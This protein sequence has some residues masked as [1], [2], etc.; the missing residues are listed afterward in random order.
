MKKIIFV[1]PQFKNGGGNRVFIELANSIHRNFFYNLE[2]AFPNN[3][4]ETNHY[5]IEKNIEIKKIGKLATNIFTKLYNTFFL[6]RY[7]IMSIKNN[8]NTIIVISDPILCV[9][10]F[11][12][13]SR[14]H[15]NIIR[16]IQADDYKIYDDL[17][18]LKNSMFL[19]F[20]KFLTKLNFKLKLS[21]IF[22]STFT[23]NCFIEI[24]KRT[25]VPKFIV[26]PAVDKNI[27]YFSK[28]IKQVSNKKI[29]L[30]LVARDHPLKK[31]E[32]FISVWRELPNETLNEIE[33][34][35]LISTDKLDKFDLKEF[36]L[37]RPSSDFEIASIM[38]KSDIFISTSMWEGF[39]LPPLEAIN[40][41]AVI[42]SSDS[43]GINEYAIHEINSLLYRP[44]D[45]IDFKIKLIELVKNFELRKVLWNNSSSIINNF[46]WD[47][48]ARIFISFIE[49][50]FTKSN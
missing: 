40:C 13:P 27:F 30:A 46:S 38:R 11:L 10:L 37:V 4:K 24:S 5:F 21:Y 16:F 41:G 45:I 1:T 39:S 8:K 28:E 7:I 49:V 33:N 44:G 29:T 23:Y 35:F 34:V 36:T 48:S 3:S 26:H 19:F 32:D 15:R 14:Y 6:F 9:F 2:I 47:K 20:F 17:F 43:G 42:L 25:D 12:I 18:V 31:L 50:N 22:N